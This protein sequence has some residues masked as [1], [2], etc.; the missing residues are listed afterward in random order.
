MPDSQ[1]LY[2]L[3]GFI[4]TLTEEPAYTPRKFTDQ[5]VIVTTGGSSRVY[6]YDTNSRSW[7]SAV[8]A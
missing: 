7:K 5:L 4:Q 3:E 2:G 1:T 6:L 8:I